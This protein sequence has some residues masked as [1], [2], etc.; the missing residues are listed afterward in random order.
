LF[1]IPIIY[2]SEPP[3]PLL[4]SRDFGNTS[5]F[6]SNL[7]SFSFCYLAGPPCPTRTPHLSPCFLLSSSFPLQYSAPLPPIIRSV[8]SVGYL[9]NILPCTLLCLLSLFF[10]DPILKYLTL[11][12]YPSVPPSSFF[13]S[14]SF[15]NFPIDITSL[16]PEHT[17]LDPHH[18]PDRLT[19]PLQPLA[20]SFILHPAKVSLASSNSI[21]VKIPSFSKGI[22]PISVLDV[23]QFPPHPRAAHF[24]FVSIGLPSYERFPF[25]YHLLNYL[26]FPILSFEFPITQLSWFAVLVAAPL[27]PFFPL[28]PCLPLNYIPS[29]F[30]S[31][32][33][34][35]V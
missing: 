34:N 4:R 35:F 26:S 14:P 2:V 18:S 17:T 1:S 33:S 23:P 16:I 28:I 8:T 30:P 6:S 25:A 29:L 5:P 20:F 21:S 12:V 22:H 15:N 27:F 3:T 31:S 11:F 10:L 32:P 9:F 13:D 24:P 19:P 7:S